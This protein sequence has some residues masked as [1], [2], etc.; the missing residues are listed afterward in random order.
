[1]EKDRDLRNVI[2]LLVQASIQWRARATAANASLA[3]VVQASPSQRM[4]L[5]PAQIQSELA[6]TAML[7]EPQ[8]AS[9][10]SQLIERLQS[11]GGDYLEPLRWYAS[12][13]LK[14]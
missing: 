9:Q 8:F 6:Q 3:R 12:Q 7:L 14:E 11:D 5:K 1:M 2:L 4:A 10:A 13:Q